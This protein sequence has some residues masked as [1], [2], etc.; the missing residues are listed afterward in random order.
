MLRFE[1]KTNGRYFYVMRSEDILNNL[2][3]T[4]IR[5]GRKARVVRHY[6]YDCRLKIDEEIKRLTKRRIKRGYVLL[7]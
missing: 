7:D 6:G 5:G 1:N 3:L 4:I 2:V